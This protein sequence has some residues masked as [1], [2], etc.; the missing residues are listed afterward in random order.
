MAEAEFTCP[1]PKRRQLHHSAP[2]GESTPVFPDVA[3]ES[4]SHSAA[5]PASLQD[6]SSQS[7]TH[8]RA[9]SFS[10]RFGR[11]GLLL[12]LAA[13]TVIVPV[14]GFVTAG[15]SVTLPSRALGTVTGMSSWT[16]PHVENSE[17]GQEL[18][19]SIT[20]ASRA[21]VRAPITVTPCLGTS[22]V[23]DGSRQ[24]DVV[25]DT[26]YWPLEKGTYV[27]TSPF[28]MRISPITGTL[29]MHEGV[30]LA[31]PMD[32]PLYSVADGKVV[33]VAENYFA[34]AFV[35]IKHERADGTVFYS[36]YLHQYTEKILVH[37]GDAVKAGQ[38]I[39][40]VG[41]SGWSTGPHLHFEIH[42]AADKVTDPMAWMKQ[43]GAIHLG[44]D[45][46]Q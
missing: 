27:E 37:E 46:C 10:S 25:S 23:A 32:T 11:V 36:V 3:G 41:T 4:T 33:E 8:S 29:H 38:P 31:A 2:A 30:D 17:V 19:G 43:A 34:G 24:I 14:S 22:S 42:D 15:S 18:S 21:R 28:G 9:A 20:A 26:I 6:Q 40:A 13:M 45:A 39:G 7:S 44:E 12:S 16:R 5:S 35:K 1:L